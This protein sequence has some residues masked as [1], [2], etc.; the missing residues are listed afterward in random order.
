MPR[1]SRARRCEPER[2][3]VVDAGASFEPALAAVLEGD[4]GRDRGLLGAVVEAFDQRRVA[5]G[6]EAAAHLLGAGEFAVVGVE[7]L[8]QDEEAPDLRAGHRG[9]AGERAVD[10]L[11]VA[12]DQLR[13]LGMAGELLI[14]GVGDAV[15]LGPIAD[16]GEFDV[17]HHRD[18]VAP[19]AERHRLAD[20]GEELELVLDVF[21]REQLAADEPADV[22]GAV[23]DLELPVRLE[24]PGVAGLDEAV[25]RSA[26]RRVFSGSSK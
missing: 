14:G 15:A 21:G 12:A 13:D 4:L 19:V 20:V 24:H 5:L 22:L 23:D 8:G 10:R 16:R 2:R 26:P 17:E 11:D 7:L 6:D 18:E 25:R 9:L 3:H 1:R